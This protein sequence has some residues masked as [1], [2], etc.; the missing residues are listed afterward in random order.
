MSAIWKPCV[1]FEL[2]AAHTYYISVAYHGPIVALKYNKSIYYYLQQKIV[3]EMLIMRHMSL[4]MISSWK[5][6]HVGVM[7]FI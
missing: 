6:L 4:S 1:D 7:T 5:P 3:K 2:G